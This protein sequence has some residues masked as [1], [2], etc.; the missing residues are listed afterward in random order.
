M[1]ASEECMEPM[2]FH[3]SGA[4]EQATPALP[5]TLEALSTRE[6]EV[7]HM[8]AQGLTNNEVARQLGIATGT[9]KAHL[10]TIYRKLG[11]RNRT[12]ALA[13]GWS[14]GLL[15]HNSRV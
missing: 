3:R 7:L 14:L 12:H 8:V 15:S 13:R 6:Q 5:L 1:I 2:I 11:V 10:Q 4:A 9:V